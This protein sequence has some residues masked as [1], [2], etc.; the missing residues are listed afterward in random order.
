MKW[1]SRGLRL[2]YAS[3][4]GRLSRP[5]TTTPHPSLPKVIGVSSRVSPFLLSTLLPIPQVDLEP[6]A[7]PSDGG[8]MSPCFAT[9]THCR[10]D[11][12]TSQARY[13]RVHVYRRAMH[14]S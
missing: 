8:G 14:A 13:V 10:L 3:P 7:L 6:H 4:C 9:T 11:R 2:G 5:R 1:P 12:L